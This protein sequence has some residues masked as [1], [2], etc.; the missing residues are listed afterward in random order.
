MAFDFFREI[1]FCE[2]IGD[3]LRLQIL[4]RHSSLLVH[5][6]TINSSIGSQSQRMDS[7]STALNEPDA[8]FEGIHSSRFSGLISARMAELFSFSARQ[9]SVGLL[10]RQESIIVQMEFNM[11]TN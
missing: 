8:L 7:P 4:Y 9:H 6:T 11:T 2:F 5:S 10:C 1:N 3:S